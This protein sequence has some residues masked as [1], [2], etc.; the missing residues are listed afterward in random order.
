MS[1]SLVHAYFTSPG[2]VHAS[3]A[4]TILTVAMAEPRLKGIAHG[5]GSQRLESMNNAIENFLTM[6]MDYEWFWIVDT[7]QTFPPGSLTTL[8]NYAEQTGATMVSGLSYAWFPKKTPPMKPHGLL[9]FNDD[10]QRRLERIGDARSIS[11]PYEMDTVS[12]G[13]LLLHR[14]LLQ[15]MANE[16]SPDHRI[17]WDAYWKDNFLVYEEL[18][19]F[20][21]AF[22]VSGQ[23][24]VIV[25]MVQIGHEREIEVDHA[26]AVEWHERNDND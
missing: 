20:E 7:D 19:F 3:F 16:Y 18:H 24:P 8:L 12:E 1:N 9:V 15:E 21:R 25:P 17:W 10:G 14:S 26:M 2:M 13:C 4:A 6:P 22:K 5:G 11:L 23:R